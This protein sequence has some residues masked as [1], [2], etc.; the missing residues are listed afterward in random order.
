MK[1]PAFF[2]ATLFALATAVAATTAVA[3]PVD[4]S[5]SRVVIVRT[6]TNFQ[7]AEALW[8]DGILFYRPEGDDVSLRRCRLEAAAVTC[9]L[10][11][12]NEITEPVYLGPNP[13][14]FTPNDD[15]SWNVERLGG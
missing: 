13:M 9:D 4:T 14:R 15:G 8:R 12:K 11:Y 6:L 1:T 10:W 2:S 5:N 3:T 7:A